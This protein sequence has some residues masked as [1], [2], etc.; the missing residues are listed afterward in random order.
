MYSCQSE[1]YGATSF[2]SAGSLAR[3][4]RASAGEQSPP[5]PISL[6]SSKYTG[7]NQV[8]LLCEYLVVYCAIRC[9]DAPMT[10]TGTSTPSCFVGSWIFGL[11][12]IGMP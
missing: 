2:I 8:S 5:L 1:R 10:D 7:I 4:T 6:S 11:L 12:H 9:L 3:V